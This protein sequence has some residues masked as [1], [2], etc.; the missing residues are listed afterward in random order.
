MRT[1]NPPIIFALRPRLVGRQM[2]LYFCPLLFGEPKQVPAFIGWPPRL[3]NP[4]NQH[5]V[6]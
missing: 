1:Q 2:W 4:L 6:N 3:T 5:M